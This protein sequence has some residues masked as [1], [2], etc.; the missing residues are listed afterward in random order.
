MCTEKEM[1]VLRTKFQTGTK[2]IFD[3]EKTTEV[4][5]QYIDTHIIGQDKSHMSLVVNSRRNSKNTW[6]KLIHDRMIERGI[7][8]GIGKN[9]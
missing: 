1:N 2:R 3:K 7:I 4:I 9:N 8:N 5:D 6:T